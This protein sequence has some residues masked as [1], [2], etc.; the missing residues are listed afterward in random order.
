MP[1][2]EETAKEQ[3][4]RETTIPESTRKFLVEYGRLSVGSPRPKNMRKR[5]ARRCFCVAVET[6]DTYS[7]E[8][9]EGVY[10]PWSTTGWTPHAWCVN[11]QGTIVDVVYPRPHEAYYFGVVV[12]RRVLSRSLKRTRMYGLFPRIEDCDEAI[13]DWRSTVFQLGDGLD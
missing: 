10:L 3:I 11:G 6:T 8:Y 12:P 13:N 4:M 5:R 7:L 9:A 1:L 2:D